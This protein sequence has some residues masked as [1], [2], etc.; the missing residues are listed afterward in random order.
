M[1][2]TNAEAK[3]LSQRVNPDGA[4]IFQFQGFEPEAPISPADYPENVVRFFT[5]LGLRT[6]HRNATIGS[7][8]KGDVGSPADMRARLLAK[9]AAWKAG[10]LR[11]ASTGEERIV[12]LVELEAACIYKAAKAAKAAGQPTASYTQFPL[13]K[14]ED[15]RGEMEALA[16][17]VINPEKVAEARAKADAEGKDADAAE[18]KVAITKLDQLKATDLFKWALLQAKKARDAKREAALA[19]KLDSPT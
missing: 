17:Q 18:A 4:V 2:D 12:P 1:S 14:P 8:T 19:A 6:A 16:D 11:I 13:P 5:L 15:V 9:I 10:E 7:E 3:K